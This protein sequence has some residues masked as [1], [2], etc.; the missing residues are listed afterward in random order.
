MH[1]AISRQHPPQTAVLSHICCFGE[2][3][4]GVSDPV[5]RA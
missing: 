3:N 4:C 1:S 2:R 5:G